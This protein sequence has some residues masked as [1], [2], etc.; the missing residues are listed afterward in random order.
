MKRGVYEPVLPWPT[1]RRRSSDIQAYIDTVARLQQDL[2]ALDSA[3]A[4]EQLA[5]QRKFDADKE[6]LLKFRAEAISSIPNFWRATL[7]N[8]PD[9]FKSQ[10]DKEILLF[11]DEIQVHDNQD[12]FGTH[13]IRL[14]FS[15]G[16][17]FFSEKELVKKIKI[18]EDNTEQITNPSISWAPGK[19]P[20]G[21]SLFDYFSADS[22]SDNDLGDILRRD[23]WINPYVY[24]LSLPPDTLVLDSPPEDNEDEQIQ[25]IYQDL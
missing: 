11:L 3:C 15:D 7:L 1:K 8:H 2:N 21:P 24:F 23:I 25:E 5:I 18:S 6:P 17:H 9:V 19:K 20:S 10:Q 12:D 4:K 16:N 22:S 14:T 13:T